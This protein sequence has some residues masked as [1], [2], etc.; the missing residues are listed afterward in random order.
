MIVQKDIIQ[1]P[2]GIKYLSEMR[3]SNGV[4]IID[5][6][7][8]Q[9]R[10]IVNKSMTGCGFTSGC[11]TNG[12]NVILASPRNQLLRNK[13]RHFNKVDTERNPR[14]EVLLFYFDRGKSLDVLKLELWGYL[15]DSDM[16]SRPYKLL[17]TYDSLGVLLD[18]LEIAP[19]N[20]NIGR[21]F[22]IVVD[23]SHCIIKDIK[24]KEYH[25]R[26]TMSAFLSRVFRY[27]SVLFVSATPIVQYLQEVSQFKQYEV[28]YYELDWPCKIQVQHRFAPC[29][30]ATD[31]FEKIYKVYE[32]QVDPEGNHYFDI[33]YNADGTYECS[34]QAVIFINSVA[35]ISFVLKK[36]I[37]RNRKIKIDD[38]SVMCAD[39]SDNRADLK[40]IDPGLKITIDIPEEGEPHPIWTFCTRTCFAGVDFCS[41]CASTYVVANYNVESLS[42]DIAS[43]LPQIIGRQRLDCNHFRSRI[44]IYYTN[45]NMVID[46]AAFD[47][48]REKKYEDS[49]KQ[50]ALYELVAKDDNLKDT[51]WGN[52]VGAI[53]SKPYDYYLSTV[54]G[55]AE[56]NPLLMLDELYCRDILKNH[57]KWFIISGQGNTQGGYSLPVQTLKDDL[58]NLQYAQ[59]KLRKVYECALKYP[60]VKDELNLMLWT[61]GYNDIAHYINNLPLDR[62]Y[63]CGFNT[64]KMDQ[65]IKA[66]Q[67][68]PSLEPAIYTRFQVGQRYTR[69]EIKI[70]LGEIYTAAGLKKTPKATDLEEYFK[71]IDCKIH[72]QRAYF[73]QS[74]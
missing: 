22:R 17:V 67:E 21:D 66:I 52:L 4:S 38:V 54:N 70:A 10:V 47:R 63:A 5:W 58:G 1:V 15:Q 20:F 28:G 11:L 49:Q 55:V 35:D 27:D 72:G 16:A 46:D 12:D 57:T 64:T 34:Y 26:N 62:L 18:I 19:F 3:D 7:L 32:K 69:D 8:G 31:A 30:N 6:L 37:K 24:L 65:E 23:E 33:I 50:I 9:G 45:S 36:Y 74:K 71:C 48:M 53:E 56:I 73:L 60:M 44:T 14:G 25:N 41:P 39:T 61:E 59:D 68:K 2:P 13:W 40:K 42:L 43:D 29:K 51:A